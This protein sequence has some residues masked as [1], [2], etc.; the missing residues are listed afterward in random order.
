[1][2]EHTDLH[3]RYRPAAMA[4]DKIAACRALATETDGFCKPCHELATRGAGRGRE[5]RAFTSYGL[6]PS[7]RARKLA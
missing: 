5:M 3:C 2:M 4:S 1:M 6:G 7:K